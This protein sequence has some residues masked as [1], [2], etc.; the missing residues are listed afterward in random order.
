MPQ[1]AYQ[2][3]LGKF[4]EEASYRTLRSPPLGG[5]STVLPAVLDSIRAEIIAVFVDG[6]K[7]FKERIWNESS[8]RNLLVTERRLRATIWLFG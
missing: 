7:V 3:T 2:T 6:V 1:S 8:L 5:G 4:C